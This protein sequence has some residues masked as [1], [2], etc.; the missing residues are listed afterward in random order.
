M[1]D[2]NE[3]DAFYLDAR[4]R[5]LLQTYALTGDLAASRGA[6]R[7]AF[8][9]AWHHWRKV[10]RLDDPE[11]WVRPIAWGQAHRRQTAR[12]WHRDKALDLEVRATLDALGKLPLNQRKVLLLTQLA[13][14][15][16]DQMAREVGIPLDRAERELQTATAQFS[17][18]RDVPTTVIRTLFE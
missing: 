8:V 15:S 4:E 12:L 16:M 1:R 3:F 17:M 6:V 2:P 10:S 7:H 5:L 13:T 9:V 14:V 11:S 18:A